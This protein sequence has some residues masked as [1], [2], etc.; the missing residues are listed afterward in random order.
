MCNFWKKSTMQ[1][2]NTLL[3]SQNRKIRFEHITIEQGLS[4]NSIICIL[5]DDYGFL[6]FCTEDGLNR[7]DGY[8]FKVFKN[9]MYAT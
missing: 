8:Q 3:S 1:E 9:N 5:Q 2:S 4:Q 7:Y 6:W